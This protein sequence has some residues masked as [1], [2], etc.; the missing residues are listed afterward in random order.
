MWKIQRKDFKDT[1]KISILVLC[2]FLDI[3]LTVVEW[4]VLEA[5]LVKPHVA[6]IVLHL[7]H[8]NVIHLCHRLLFEPKI[9][10]PLFRCKKNN[11]QMVK[12]ETTDSKYHSTAGDHYEASS[13]SCPLPCILSF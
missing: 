5:V 10:P 12:T 7:G 11:R 13:S 8:H 1:K 2:L 9:L 6:D 3:L 4:R